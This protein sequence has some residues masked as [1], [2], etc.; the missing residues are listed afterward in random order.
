M[1]N[2]QFTPN[3]ISFKQIKIDAKRLSK[4][5]DKTYQQALTEVVSQ[6]TEF[7]NWN[8]LKTHCDALG[9][10]VLRFS[11]KQKQTVV[12]KKKPIVI[13][14]LSDDN[15]ELFLKE[16]HTLNKPSIIIEDKHK[17][18]ESL[19]L[20]HTST[21]ENID[22]FVKRSHFIVL[23]ESSFTSFNSENFNLVLDSCKKQGKALFFLNNPY[24]KVGESLHSYFQDLHCILE[25]VDQKPIASL[26]SKLKGIQSF[27]RVNRLKLEPIIKPISEKII[28][29]KIK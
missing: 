19:F 26:S 27:S 21:F 15:L 4:C 7:R 18:D 3:G 11:Y 25:I 2:I 5:E 16:L 28:S 9:G 1:K 6:K 13:S 8:E 17:I 10:S 24:S 29:P 12:F 22:D 20:E 23:K 14:A